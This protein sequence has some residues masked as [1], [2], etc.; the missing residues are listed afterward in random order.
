MR[1]EFPLFGLFNKVKY[2]DKMMAFRYQLS[3]T[4]TTLRSD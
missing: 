2:V 1:S 4:D 3:N